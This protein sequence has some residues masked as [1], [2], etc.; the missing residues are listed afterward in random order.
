MTEILWVLAP[1]AFFATAILFAY[2]C[3]RLTR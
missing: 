1:F 3:D 2:G